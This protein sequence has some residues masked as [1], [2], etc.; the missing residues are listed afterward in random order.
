MEDKMESFNEQKKQQGYVMTL[1][2]S[3][4]DIDQRAAYE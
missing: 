3:S 2:T 4:V 1:C